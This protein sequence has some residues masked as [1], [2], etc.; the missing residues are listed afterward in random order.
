M[1]SIG[2]SISEA[3]KLRRKMWRR[4]AAAVL[5][6]MIATGFNT[7]GEGTLPPKPPPNTGT[8]NIFGEAV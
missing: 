7:C 2:A 4:V 1:S 6:F 3:M 8:V 5:F